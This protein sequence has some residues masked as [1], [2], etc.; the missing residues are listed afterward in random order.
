MKYHSCKNEEYII[1]RGLKIKKFLFLSAPLQRKIQHMKR[2]RLLILTAFFTF[3]LNAQEAPAEKPKLVVGIVVDQMRYDYLTRFWER[4]GDNGFK[5]LVAEGFNFKNN[6]FNYIPTYTGPGHASIYTG[7][8]PMNHGIIGNNWYDKFAEKVVYVT[9]DASVNSIGTSSDAGKMS[10]HKM[11]STTVADKNRLHTQF[12][13]KTI[14]VALKD[15]GS[16]LPA[17]HTANA[18]YWFHGADEGKWITST[19]YLEKLPQWVKDFNDS[20]IAESYLKP[21]N[22]LYDIKTYTESGDDINEFERGFKGKETA[23]LPYDLKKLAPLNNNFDIIKIVPYGNDLTTS[24]ALAAIKGEDLG[25]DEDTDFLTLSYSSPDYVGHN[26]GVNSKEVE[27][28]YL[29]L[30]QN[31][32]ELLEHLDQQVGKGNYTVFL[33]ADHGAVDVPAYLESVKI[34][35]GYFNTGQLRNKIEKHLSAEFGQNDLVE[36]ISNNQVFLNY[37]A[38]QEK[39]INIKEL[40]NAIAHL[41]LQED[42]ID[43]VYTRSQLEATD[44][45][46]GIAA[47]IENGF[48]QRR[49]GDILYVLD[50]AV[51][52]SS[53]RKGTTHGSGFMYDTHA[54]LIFFGNGIPQGSTYKRS[55]IT[56]IAPTISALLGIGFPNAATGEPLYI[57]L[58]EENKK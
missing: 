17:G 11:K 31:I 24:F 33:T 23:S 46:T 40:E 58:D 15:R 55:E 8:S 52:A 34:P 9:E 1:Y 47:S 49:S 39:N 54:P 26:F 21:W 12:R 50:P 29:R 43:K 57:M 38:I 51:I 45:T 42:M 56:D 53:S 48:N 25:K 20:N 35:A 6:H 7:T 41:V 3:Q 28:T 5:R 30:D 4:F 10:P 19:F 36:N 22:T 27:D 14:G 18:A 16:I 13:G 37:E 2:A 44:F 32:G